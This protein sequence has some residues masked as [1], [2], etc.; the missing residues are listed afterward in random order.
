MSGSIEE[1]IRNVFAEVFAGKGLVSPEIT[2]DTVLDTSLG[3]ESLDF[4]EIVL[5]L[6]EEFGFDPFANGIPPHVGVFGDLAPLYGAP[7]VAA[8]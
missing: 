8:S 2:A 5:R 4:A 7:P 6:E 1:R 3:L